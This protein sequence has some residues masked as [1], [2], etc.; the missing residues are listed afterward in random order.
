MAAA[1]RPV[2]F[3]LT[4][5]EGSTRLLRIA[6]DDY[7]RLVA[8]Q[9]A[10]I[11]A[12]VRAADG[13]MRPFEG[14]GCLAVFTH[15]RDGVH[16]AVDAQRRLAAH[17]W[18]DALRVRVRMGVHTGDAILHEG[19]HFG[20]ALH[21]AARVADAGHGGQV[22]VS[23]AT[24]RAI[25]GVPATV[26]LT[27]LGVHRLKDLD[28]PIHLFQATA[29][30]RTDHFP[31]LRTLRDT[32]HNLPQQ[33]STLIGRDDDIT[34]IVGMLRDHR[35][36]TVTGT[37]GVGKTR[38]AVHVGAL[39]SDA[40]PDGVWLIELARTRRSAEV[41]QLIAEQLGVDG[42]TDEGAEAAITDLL[43]ERSALLILD[44]FE[45]VIAAA[46][47]VSRILAGAPRVR[48]LVTSRERLLIDG[49]RTYPLAPLPTPDSDGATPGQV[50]ASVA[51]FLD[52]ARSHDPTFNPTA[53]DLDAI[54]EV[55]SLVDGLPL[56]IELAAAQ[57]RVLPVTAVRDR[58]ELGF[59]ALSGRARDRPAR[60]R[61]LRAT[62]GWS[63]DLL[64][65]E[66]Q[67]LLEALAAFDG[68]R[69]LDAVDA[70][71]GTDIDVVAGLTAL[72][73]KSLVQRRIGA[74]GDVRFVL[75][76]IV[77]EFARERLDASGH[78]DAVRAAHAQHFAALAETADDG[79]VNE[80]APGWE[81]RVSENLGNIRAALRWAF[82]GGDAALGVRITAALY[83]Y[84]RWGGAYDEGRAW[85]DR[86]MQHPDLL[87]C[88][89]RGRLHAALGSYEIDADPAGSRH[90]WQA[91][92]ADLTT[93]GDQVRAVHALGMLALTYVGDDDH[94]DEACRLTAE[95]V[96]IAR[97]I[98]GNRRVLADALSAMGEVAR[99]AGDLAQAAAAYEEAVALIGP[100][101]DQRYIAILQSNLAAVVRHRGD[102]LTAL[103]LSTQA[104]AT[105]AKEARRDLAAM[106]L[107]EVA[108]HEQGVG[109]AERS[110]T[111][112]GAANAAMARLRFPRQ[113]VD[114]LEYERVRSDLI[115]ALGAERVAALEAAGAELSLDDAIDVAL[116]GAATDGSG[117]AV[118]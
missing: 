30:G 5:I 34:A 105:L 91:A 68:G 92:L 26:D 111:L 70:V 54:G 42:G 43:R 58:L 97:T 110:A 93:C 39:T 64:P 56:A 98:R 71:C 78:A 74:D 3:L 16:A 89:M 79:L 59:D 87:D 1:A 77:H 33:P 22:L 8:E 19:E 115:A 102:P 21:R 99:A 37:G 44:N 81:D 101:G 82:D 65:E 2:T 114:R 40:F 72:V 109:R 75:L 12:A 31:P 36:V 51:L 106:A 69:S 9:R 117:Q 14:D 46:P 112:F 80:N 6:G 57:S 29:A 7:P 49:E 76:E 95:G 60:H 61:T 118:G 113:P 62:L 17:P 24:C 50:S 94:Y 107:S 104:L 90:H 84:W 52:R 27:D 45:H 47:V 15:A 55:C 28:A 11:G 73:D 25:A 100:T 48:A 67:R 53:G 96:R 4:D 41:T 35:L 83:L 63:Y 18:P 103:Q 108:G 116:S 13:A 86:A 32:G 23:A 10:L 66:E 38:I 88:A 85:V 20:L